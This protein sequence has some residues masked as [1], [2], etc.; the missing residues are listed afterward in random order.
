MPHST[1]SHHLPQTLHLYPLRGFGNIFQKIATLLLDHGRLKP[2]REDP[3]DSALAFLRINPGDYNNKPV[4]HI[5]P[6]RPALEALKEILDGYRRIMQQ[7]IKGACENRDPEFLHDFLHAARRTQCLLNHY[8]TSLP[9]RSIDLIRQDFDWIEKLTAPVRNLDIYLGLFDEFLTRVDKDHRQALEPLRGFLEAEKMQE[10][11]QMQVPLE[12]PRYRR[13]M[14][15]WEQIL[16]TKTPADGLP[17]EA[18]L[19]IIQLASRGIYGIYLE[20]IHK[21]REVERAITTD[22]LLELQCIGK[23]LGYEMETFASLYP[24]EQLKPLLDALSPLQ[25][26]LNNYYDMHLQHDSLLEYSQKMKQQRRTMPLWLEAAEQ[27]AEDRE[28][29]ER[30]MQSEFG[31]CYKRIARKKMRKRVQNLFATGT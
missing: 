6:Q 14:S 27:L 30:K 20:M 4:L 25:E 24:E 31:A 16:N 26:N 18:R 29:E 13:T 19:P 10:Q 23:K 8:L 7:N 1:E 21:G 28:R 9:I 11:R 22:G 15:N 12:S 2:A 17:Q 5:D 3:L